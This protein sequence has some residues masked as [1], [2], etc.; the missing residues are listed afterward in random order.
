MKKLIKSLR[1]RS[2]TKIY[3]A[4]LK[5]P[6]PAAQFVAWLCEI[7]GRSESSVRKWLAGTVQPEEHIK[8][9]ISKKTDI[10]VAELFPKKR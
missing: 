7:T 6:S 10:P 1:V 8:E 3:K 9:K 2:L 4:L 5:I